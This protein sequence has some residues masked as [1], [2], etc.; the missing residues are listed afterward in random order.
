MILT[1]HNLPAS[2]C[3]LTLIPDN[4]MHTSV[5][6]TRVTRTVND[7]E[8][9]QR[10]KT[11]RW[12]Q[13]CWPSQ[14]AQRVAPDSSL[15][16]SL[17]PAPHKCPAL[18]QWQVESGLTGQAPLTVR[19][20]CLSVCYFRC[21][22]IHICCVCNRLLTHTLADSKSYESDSCYSLQMRPGFAGWAPAELNRFKN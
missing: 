15:L 18:P 17:G 19:P 14:C 20:S 3:Q 16:S 22:R 11:N 13:S 9:T 6:L 12:C 7:T 4:H 21:D 10:Q 1:R 2:I 5:T 8:C